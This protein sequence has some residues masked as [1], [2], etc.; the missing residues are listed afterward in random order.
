VGSDVGDVG[1]S[2][3]V[4][5]VGGDFDGIG[6]GAIVGENV[7]VMISEVAGWHSHAPSNP[8]RKPHALM[9]IAP[10]SPA[11]CSIPHGTAGWPGN[12]K[13]ASGLPTCFPSPQTEHRCAF[14]VAAVGAGVMILGILGLGEGAGVGGFGV[15]AI[16]GENVGV[17]VS[18]V[19][20]WHSHAPSNTGRKIH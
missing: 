17:M 18:E 4:L 3:T 13:I 8:G 6:V 20:G 11:A 19:A 9:G 12:S 7:G 15:G 2:V 10:L 14:T 5:G 1:V 16:V